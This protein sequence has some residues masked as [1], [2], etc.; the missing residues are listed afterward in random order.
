MNG[1]SMRQ[2]KVH[3]HCKCSRTSTVDEVIFTRKGTGTSGQRMYY[4]IPGSTEIQV[5]Y[6]SLPSLF[7]QIGYNHDVLTDLYFRGETP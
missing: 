7:P 2:W 4:L 6:V 5:V 1:L 3:F